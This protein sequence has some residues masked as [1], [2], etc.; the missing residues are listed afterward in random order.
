MVNEMCIGKNG[1]NLIFIISPPRS[2]STLLQRIIAR[3]PDVHTTAEPW[4]LLPL[5]YT[6]RQ[7]GHRA[8][9]DADLAYIALTDFLTTLP[10]GIN[11]YKNEIR[12]TAVTV[13]NAACMTAGKSI[14]LDKTPRY[15]FIIPELFELFPQ[16]KFVFLYR[17]PL[18]ILNSI[19]ETRVKKHW[20]LLA[21]YRHD[22]LTAP[23]SLLEAQELMSNACYTLRYEELVD[24]PIEQM[25]RLF[26]F[27]QLDF[28]PDFLDYGSED[29]P[30]GKMGD[31]QTIHN[32]N[33]PVQ[34]R[35]ERWKSAF[36][37]AYEQHYARAYV[38]DL[39]EGTFLR[40]GYPF[41]QVADCLAQFSDRPIN[42]EFSWR[43][44]MSPT[45]T[46]RNRLYYI[47]LA[48]LEHRRLIQ[49]FRRV[50]RRTKKN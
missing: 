11:M 46:T 16:A 7:A 6:W 31:Q 30:A 26:D 18:G 25:R 32:Y 21:R 38:Q 50:F 45:V 3:H 14:F 13:Y 12:R 5:M 33:Q 34:D 43:A 9:Y 27:L 22:L 15:Y 28:Q 10:D 29:P 2:G 37:D 24:Q 19:L 1:N 49:K 41:E 4:L 8:E 47:E 48:L 17:H 35:S 20:I 36:I 44:L 42:H 39:G 23:A 40:L